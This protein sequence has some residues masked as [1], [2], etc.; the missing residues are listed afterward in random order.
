VLRRLGARLVFRAG[1]RRN[2]RRTTVYYRP[3]A[4]AAARRV[5]AVLGHAPVRPYRRSLGAAGAVIVVAGR[6]RLAVPAP[7]A[8]V[9]VAPG[10]SRPIP[11]VATAPVAPGDSRPIP[12]VA[13]APT[14]PLPPVATAPTRPLPP[15][16]A[17]PAPPRTPKPPQP[18]TP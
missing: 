4:R 1:A 11:P 6:D 10:D 2:A 17:T 16:S 14:R 3:G 15:P 5:A 7:V 8:V 12:P 9:P 13:T 18:A